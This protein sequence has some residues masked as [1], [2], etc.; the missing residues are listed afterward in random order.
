MPWS[1]RR[2]FQLLPLNR[3]T[4]GQK[5]HS[6]AIA[7][8]SWFI[9]ES[10]RK[11]AQKA[12]A[13]AADANFR[14]RIQWR[15]RRRSNWI[16]WWSIVLNH[17]NKMAVSGHHESDAHGTIRCSLVSVG[18]GVRDHFFQTQVDRKM[19]ALGNRMP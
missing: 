15:R 7:W 4:T 14:L 17:E 18:N 13:L 5:A 10:I 2:L 3:G 9:F 6:Q 11:P 16:E 1:S 19:N 12:E 8:L